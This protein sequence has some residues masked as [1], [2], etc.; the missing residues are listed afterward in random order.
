MTHARPGVVRR[1]KRADGHFHQIVAMVDEEQ[2]A[3]S[4][5]NSSR[6]SKNVIDNAQ[7]ALIHDHIAHRLDRSMKTPSFRRKAALA[8]FGAIT[9]YL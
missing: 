6:R 8:A 9:R 7:K 2:P 3:L 5:P 4:S 1:L